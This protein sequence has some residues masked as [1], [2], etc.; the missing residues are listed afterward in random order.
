MVSAILN[1]RLEV[2]RGGKPGISHRQLQDLSS[3]N[4]SILRVSGKSHFHLDTISAA[5][6]Q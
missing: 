3:K 2:E 1:A 5:H 6:E 4:R